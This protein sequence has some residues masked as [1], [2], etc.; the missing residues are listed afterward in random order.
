M[1]TY[2]SQSDLD[3]TWIYLL[4]NLYRPL[5]VLVEPMNVFLPM[6]LRVATMRVIGTPNY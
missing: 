2:K 5:Q 1:P 3:M 4:H 6:I